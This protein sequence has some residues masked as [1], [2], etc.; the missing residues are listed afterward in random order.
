MECALGF[1]Q[2]HFLFDLFL[3]MFVMCEHCIAFCWC[4]KNS[5]FYLWFDIC[6]SPMAN[7]EHGA[8]HPAIVQWPRSNWAYGQIIMSSFY[9]NAAQSAGPICEITDHS[10][11]FPWHLDLECSKPFVSRSGGSPGFLELFLGRVS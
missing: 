5:I 11:L 6:R 9:S 8:Q 2:L 1:M 10:I 4:S 7:F 3:L